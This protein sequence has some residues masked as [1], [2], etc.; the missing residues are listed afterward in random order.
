MFLTGCSQVTVQATPTIAPTGMLTPYLTLTPSPQLPTATIQVTIPVTPAPTPTPFLYTVKNDD[1]MLGIAIQFG[2]KLE[3]LQAANPTVDPHFMGKGFQLVIPITSEIPAVVPT[4]T[5]VPVRMGEPHCYPAGDGGAWCVVA[6]KNDQPASLENLS[7]WIGL[8]NDNNENIASQVAYAPLN[9]LRSGSTIPL[10]VYFAPPLP[11]E[12][13][14][15]VELLSA[16]TVAADDPRYIDSQV[17]LDQVE[18]TADGSGAAV[19]G[20]VLLPE[21]APA[22]SQL[23]LLAVA[24]DAEGNIVGERKWKSAGETEFDFTVYS[25]S[26]AIDHVEVLSEARP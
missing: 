16:L 12:F 3:D 6:T 14:P 9:I 26:G 18:I 8:Y 10:M 15:Q 22:L 24:Y 11:A 25:L 13:R 23:W 4:P 5:A 20:Q 2:I 17:Q 19:R 21:N 1:T 7:A